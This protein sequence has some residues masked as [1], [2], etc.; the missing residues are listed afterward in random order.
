[1]LFIP[2]RSWVFFLIIANIAI[3][4][5]LI[6]FADGIPID[7]FPQGIQMVGTAIPVVYVVGMFPDVESKDRL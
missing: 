5:G 7:D 4:F 3:A 2:F 6:S 1:M